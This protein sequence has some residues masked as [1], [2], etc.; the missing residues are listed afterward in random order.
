MKKISLERAESRLDD[1][2]SLQDRVV[3]LKAQS[4]QR[5]DCPKSNM[6]RQLRSIERRWQ[7]AYRRRVSQNDFKNSG[8]IWS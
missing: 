5:L 2:K 7:S 3:A 1:A 8:P 6:P 4:K